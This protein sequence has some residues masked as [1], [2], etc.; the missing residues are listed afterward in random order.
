MPWLSDQLDSFACTGY[1]APNLHI[2]GRIDCVRPIVI[3]PLSPDSCRM[4]CYHLFPKELL[5]RADFAEKSKVYHDYQVE[6]LEEDRSMI[7]SMQHA[8]AH[9]PSV[10]ARYR[11]WSAPS[12]T[13]SIITSS[14]S[15]P[16]HRKAPVPCGAPAPIVTKRHSVDR[17]A[18]RG[19][20]S[21]LRPGNEYAVVA[22]LYHHRL[23]SRDIASV[24]PAYDPADRLHVPDPEERIL[25]VLA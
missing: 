14:A 21:G 25:E 20:C 10:P 3:W 15:S 13:P 12:T 2:F 11:R 4:V 17:A 24:V 8:T 5:A 6:V 22:H 1:L 19:P 18:G 9:R 7:Q 16:N 23:I